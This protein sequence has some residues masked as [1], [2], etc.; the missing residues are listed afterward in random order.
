MVGFAVVMDFIRHTSRRSEI[1][2]RRKIIS[3]RKYIMEGGHKQTIFL[4]FENNF[5][6]GFHKTY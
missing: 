2:S 3:T 4:L 5:F 6:L 1:L